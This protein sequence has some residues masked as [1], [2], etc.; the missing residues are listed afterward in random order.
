MSKSEKTVFSLFFFI[1]D[2][3]SNCI[4]RNHNFLAHTE[5]PNKFFSFFPVL[6]AKKKKK[7]SKSSVFKSV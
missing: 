3:V 5:A 4:N 1:Q 6:G 2:T 7:P